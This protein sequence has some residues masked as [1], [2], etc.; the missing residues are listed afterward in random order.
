MPDRRAP[1]IED[2]A[3]K[4][5][6]DP[7]SG[8][9][10]VPLGGD[11]D[12]E[13]RIRVGAERA[14]IDK[15]EVEHVGAHVRLRTH[16][17]EIPFAEALRQERVEIERIPVGRVV[18]EA[19]KVRI[20]VG[21]TIVPVVEEVLVRMFRVVEEVRLSVVAETVEHRETVTLR[22]QEAIID[23]VPSGGGSDGA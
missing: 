7:G 11:G 6:H 10:Q 20:E 17:D 9:A 1:V 23:D 16:E 21:V 12:T 4:P 3:G 13:Q 14:V 19:P 15:R 8:P 22:Q 5:G 2:T 18:D